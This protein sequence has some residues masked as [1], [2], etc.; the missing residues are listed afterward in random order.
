MQDRMP[1]PIDSNQR[2]AVSWWLWISWTERANGGGLVY[3]CAAH[4]FHPAGWAEDA[5]FEIPGGGQLFIHQCTVTDEVF[6]RF[7][8]ALDAGM[9]DTGSAISSKVIQARVA[10]TRVVIQEGLGQ[11]AVPTGLYYTLPNVQTL[12]GSADGALERIVSILQEQLNLPFKGAYAGHLDNF[13]IFELHPWLDAPLPFLIEAI[14]DP[15]KNRNG[16]QVMVICRTPGFAAAEHTAHLV[17]RANQEVIFDGLIRLP[18][19]QRRVPVQLPQW[20]DQFDF[21]VFG[22]DGQRLLHS[23]QRSF[24]NSRPLPPSRPPGLNGCRRS[25]TTATG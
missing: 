21:H 10:A 24:L 13:E 1:A 17:G 19:R 22:D 11:S 6:G 23:E 2:P 7:R 25:S 16:P 20:L 3:G 14:P 18:P 12:V 9:V 15:G 4:N 8:N 5:S